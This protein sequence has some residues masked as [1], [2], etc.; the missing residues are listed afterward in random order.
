[1]EFSINHNH[2]LTISRIVGYVALAVLIFTV[3]AAFVI[4]IMWIAYYYFYDKKLAI[5]KKHSYFV[6]P[7]FMP[8]QSI[9]SDKN[10]IANTT[11][12]IDKAKTIVTSDADHTTTVIENEMQNNC[13][14]SEMR[15][16]TPQE[17][18]NANLKAPFKTKVSK[19]IKDRLKI[20]SKN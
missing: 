13:L 16:S 19:W 1:M 15:E 3:I 6:S 17:N 5:T 14:I 7:Y 20:K 4:A 10:E 12:E 11:D 8:L 18:V 2:L 9:S